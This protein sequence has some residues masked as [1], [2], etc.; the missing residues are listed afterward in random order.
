MSCNAKISIALDVVDTSAESEEAPDP[1]S[2]DSHR[3]APL[4]HQQQHRFHPV[5]LD[6]RANLGMEKIDRS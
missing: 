5:N 6:P 4:V 3:T 1:I 2:A